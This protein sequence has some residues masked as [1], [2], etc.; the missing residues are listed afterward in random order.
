MSLS[1]SNKQILFLYCATLASTIIGVLVSVLNTRNLDP[2]AYG[3]VRYVN[4]IIQF[5]AG[6]LSF[7]Y[8]VSGSRL[9][10]ISPSR[11][12]T[13]NLKGILIVILAVTVVAMIALMG[14]VG[15]IH[16]YLKNPAANL[17][18]IAIPV[19]AAPLML[20]YVNTVFQ[21]D[22]QIGRIALGRLLPPLMYLC[23]A[24]FVYRTYGA[25]TSRMILLQNGISVVVLALLIYYSRPSFNRLRAAFG[26]L[27]AENRQY[28]IQVYYGSICGVS[29]GYLAGVTLGIFNTSNEMVGLYT[30]ALTISAPL[31]ML[32]TII[33]TAYFKQFAT[34]D[35]IQKNIILGTIGISVLSLIVYVSLIPIITSYLYPESYSSI[36][37]YAS[38]LAVGTTIHGIGDMFNRFLGAH[39][40]GKFLQHGAI[41]TGLVL[42]I[43]N[44]LFVWLWNITGA[45]VTK[46]L[47]SACYCLIMV[48]YYRKLTSNHTAVQ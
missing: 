4:N 15:V 17:F 30:L 44:I 18:F 21:G 35:H 11:K 20:N 47:S 7:G 38:V 43:G 36:A 26:K 27:R 23:I 5:L 31:A 6:F 33:G 8:F 29:L 3:D 28:G 1:R 2:E 40:Q 22:N 16:I 41:V 19:C 34:S 46:I 48:Y 12:R 9:L 32:P 37:L 24:Y 14:V 25:T 42:L 39:G 10:A 13:A 45:I